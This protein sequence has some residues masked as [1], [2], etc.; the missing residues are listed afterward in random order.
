MRGSFFVAALALMAAAVGLDCRRANG[1]YCD[2]V[3][4]CATGFACDVAG[5]ECHATSVGGGGGDMS[6]GEGGVGGC[7]QCGGATP[8]CVAMSCVSC[9][10]TSDPEGACSAAAPS[11][12]HCL[13][14]GGDAGSCAG[15]RD[16]GDC[17]TVTP[18]C[19]ATTHAC[20]GCAADSECPSLVCD[21]TPGSTTH[22]LCI[23]VAKVEYVDGNAAMNGNGLLPTTP[24]QKIQ[25]AINHATGGDNRPYVHIAAGTYN[26][27]PGVANSA[28]IYLVGADGAF[29][30]PM[31]G[32]GIGAQSGGSMTVRN[33]V[34]TATSGNAANCQ[35]ATL[36]AYRT[37]L[38]NSAQLGVYSSACQLLVDACWI[39]GNSSGGVSVSGSFT[40]INSIITKNGAIGGITQ[41]VTGTTMVFANNTVADNTS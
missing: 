17:S 20:R 18:F 16:A 2:D 8:I 9:L 19:D 10:S 26:E 21:L 15:C 11:T 38:I 39:H 31:N 37:Q 24:R 36:T 1:A 22:G 28:S 40:I 7:A 32:D 33:L 3:R 27:N 6:V 12:P 23:A 13:V 41:A 35:N 29:I 25:D 34:V 14:S 30:H 5:R 4:P